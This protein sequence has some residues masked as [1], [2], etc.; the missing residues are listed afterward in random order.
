MT[1][2]TEGRHAAEFLVSEANHTRS[3][4]TITVKSGENLVAGQLIELSG[5][6][7][8]AASG[9]LESDGTLTTALVGIL[10][11]N[12]DATDAAVAG[13]VYI[14][15]DAEVNDAELTYPTESTAGGEKAACIASL[16]ALGI[17]V[18]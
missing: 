11:D 8:V 3:R 6:E 12:V 13:C 17:I 5:S 14:A 15:R 7:A 9:D 1:V 2:L 16:K 10:F 4:E 18:R